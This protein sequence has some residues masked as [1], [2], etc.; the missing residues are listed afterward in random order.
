M[1]GAFAVEYSNLETEILVFRSE[2]EY[3]EFYDQCHLAL[4]SVYK[5]TNFNSF[6]LLLDGLYGK[7]SAERHSQ[8]REHYG[9]SLCIGTALEA[10]KRLPPHLQAVVRLHAPFSE[11]NRSSVHG[12]LGL[13]FERKYNH[14]PPSPTA[15]PSVLLLDTHSNFGRPILLHPEAAPVES[16][17]NSQ[18]NSP[19]AYFSLRG[20]IIY[21]Q[22]GDV[23]LEYHHRG[24]TDECALKLSLTAISQYPYVAVISY[25]EGGGP[26][27]FVKVHLV[28]KTIKFFYREEKEVR[29][30][31]MQ[32]GEDERVDWKGCP[33][34][35][36]EGY[37]ADL[38]MRG[39]EALLE[40]IQSIT[41]NYSKVMQLRSNWRAVLSLL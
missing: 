27:G 19:R 17:W 34:W 1:S 22:R 35:I 9:G 40:D 11:G 14:E 31:S 5:D 29:E 12:F 33:C 26:K 2:Q 10:R 15:K 20:D 18:P 37:A 4:E 24:V 36:N 21:F 3:Q 7:V 28:E 23:Y 6:S 25:L 13:W 32:F 16:R 38:K 30:F 8:H 41:T 39:I